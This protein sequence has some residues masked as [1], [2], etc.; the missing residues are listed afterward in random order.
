MLLIN[1]G[2]S[3]MSKGGNPHAASVS[4]ISVTA[5]DMSRDGSAEVRKLDREDLPQLLHTL[6]ASKRSS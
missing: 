1:L 6:R 2:T 4:C 5:C 3:K